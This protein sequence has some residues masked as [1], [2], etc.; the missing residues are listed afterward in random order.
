MYTF[1]IMVQAVSPHN[2]KTS[3]S[4]MRY[5]ETLKSTMVAPMVLNTN[6]MKAY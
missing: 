1:S 2:L 6:N 5:V 3:S 4:E